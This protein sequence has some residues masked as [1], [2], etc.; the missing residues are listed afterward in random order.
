M[1]RFELGCFE[2]C[3]DIIFESEFKKSLAQLC[4]IHFEFMPYGRSRFTT[5]S[6]FVVSQNR[7][8]KDNIV[9]LLS[10]WDMTLAYFP[11]VV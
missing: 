2:S 9:F 1:F 7:D 11:I 6:T 4:R 8:I 5:V 10:L 3:R